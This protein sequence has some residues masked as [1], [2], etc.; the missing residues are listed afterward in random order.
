VRKHGLLVPAK[1]LA[2]RPVHGAATKNMNVQMI[3]SLASIA[4]AVD[5]RAKAVAETLF[6]RQVRGDRQE[7]AEQRSMLF[8]SVR[9][10]LQMG[11]RNDQKM[12][13]GLGRD[14]AEGKHL[15][16]LVQRLDGNC[17]GSN[18]AEEAVGILR[19]ADRIAPGIAPGLGL[20]IPQ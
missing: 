14:V 1:K 4:A 7:V 8:R 2:R 11:A 9:E 20:R 12:H 19:H 16:I 5:D 6:S 3:D 17:A 15:L 13:R 18:F 10:R